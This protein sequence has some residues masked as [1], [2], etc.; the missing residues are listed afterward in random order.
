[1]L[2]SVDDIDAK[3]RQ[4]EAETLQITQQLAIAD[5]SLA[6]DFAVCQ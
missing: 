1:M 6:E 2:A 5:Q 3:A 4:L